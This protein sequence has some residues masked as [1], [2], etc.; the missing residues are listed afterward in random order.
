MEVTQVGGNNGTHPIN[1]I[2]TIFLYELRFLVSVDTFYLFKTE[3][4][5]KQNIAP[6]YNV[7]KNLTHLLKTKHFTY[8]E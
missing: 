5:P 3:Q 8:S 1:S 6:R 4:Y 2:K 7:K